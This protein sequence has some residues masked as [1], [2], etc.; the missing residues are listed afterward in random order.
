MMVIDISDCLNVNIGDS[1]TLWGEGLA[2]ETVAAHMNIQPYSLVTC[3]TNRV[4]RVACNTPI[5][6]TTTRSH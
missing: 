5:N 1:V 3:L 6:T 4:K 2:I